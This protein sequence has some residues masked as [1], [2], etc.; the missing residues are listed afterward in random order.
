MIVTNY[1]E[2]QQ[3]AMELG[4]ERGFGKLSLNDKQTIERLSQYLAS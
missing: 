4:A 1:E 3:A 2:H